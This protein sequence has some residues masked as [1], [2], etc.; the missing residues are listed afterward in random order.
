MQL[1]NNYTVYWSPVGKLQFTLCLLEIT[2]HRPE[3]HTDMLRTYSCT[4]GEMSEWVGCQCWTSAL[5]GWGGYGALLKSTWQCPGGELASLQ[6]PI[7]TLYF[8]PYWDLNQRPS[9]SQ[10][11]SLRTELLPPLYLVWDVG[12]IKQSILCIFLMFKISNGGY[13]HWHVFSL[14]RVMKLFYLKW[15]EIMWKVSVLWEAIQFSMPPSPAKSPLG[16]L[17]QLP[18]KRLLFH[19]N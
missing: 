1:Y 9:G 15:W 7:H 12:W 19:K 14:M 18:H 2:T 3:I 10:P 6:L 17:L 16:L 4:N 8:G 11:K 5:S 13:E